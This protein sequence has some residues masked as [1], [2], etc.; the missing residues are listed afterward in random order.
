MGKQIH[1][2]YKGARGAIVGQGELKKK[3]YDPLFSLNQTY[4]MFRDNIK[5]LARRTWCTTKRID[6]LKHLL[7]I[8]AHY[9]NQVIDKIK[10]PSIFEYSAPIR[11]SS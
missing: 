5:R 2:R 10:R 9:H 1:E 8:Y 7:F 4:A 11:I 6:R 3:N